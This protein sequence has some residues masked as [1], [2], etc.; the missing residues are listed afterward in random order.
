MGT[1]KV[2]EFVS[3]GHI[4]KR[5]SWDKCRSLDAAKCVQKKCENIQ[6]WKAVLSGQLIAHPVDI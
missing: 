3:P 1:S 2:W 6:P 4:V 5:G